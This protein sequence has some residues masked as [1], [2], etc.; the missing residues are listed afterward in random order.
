MGGGWGVAD[1][2]FAAVCVIE[3]IA[4][5]TLVLYNTRSYST[6]MGTGSMTFAPLI[7]AGSTSWPSQN[8]GS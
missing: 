7:A 3:G 8:M 4:R 6:A 2:I 1:E 5:D